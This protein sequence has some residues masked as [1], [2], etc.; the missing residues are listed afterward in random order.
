MQHTRRRLKDTRDTANKR[1]R[2]FLQPTFTGN[3]REKRSSLFLLLFGNC[4]TS[5]TR[6]GREAG[7][8]AYPKGGPGRWGK[9][10]EE[11]TKNRRKRHKNCIAFFWDEVG[12]R[13]KEHPS[14][15]QREREAEGQGRRKREGRSDF[16]SPSLP[17]S[18][19][20]FAPPPFFVSVRVQNFHLLWSVA[21]PCSPPPPF[22]IHSGMGWFLL[23]LLLRWL[24]PPLLLSR[25][26]EEEGRE[27]GRDGGRGHYCCDDGERGGRGRVERGRKKE[28]C[29][30]HDEFPLFS[31]C[32]SFPPPSSFRHGRRRKG[33]RGKKG[34]FSFRSLLPLPPPRGRGGGG[35]KL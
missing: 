32:L 12:R 25:E 17:P 11:A 29:S 10:E 8:P 7:P 30:H 15:R 2:F 1:G 35:G 5:I 28:R 9:E 21:L 4:T 18:F 13:R 34:G 16:F 22:H 19:P 24:L 20:F 6:G 23:L 33:G 31:L 14:Q 3:D 27:E 26:W